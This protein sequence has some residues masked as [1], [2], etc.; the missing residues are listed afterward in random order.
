VARPN[1]ESSAA[2]AV[3]GTVENHVQLAAA[4]LMAATGAAV[5]VCPGI[6][7]GLAVAALWRWRSRPPVYLRVAVA[8]VALVPLFAL[9][10]FVE[11][12]WLWRDM[13]ANALPS[14]LKGVDGAL[15]LR[16]VPIEALAGAACLEL[17]GVAITLATRTIGGQI[18]RD[19]RLDR[20]RWRAISGHRGLID[21]LQAMLNQDSYSSSAAHPS[22]FVRLG[23]DAEI[24]RPLD[25]RLPNELATHV[26]IPGTSG[27][28]K[29]TTLARLADGAIAS[30][31]G[32]IF[33]DCKGGGL[34]ATARKLAA[35]YRVPFFLVD[36]DDPASLGYNP[37]S[38]DASAVANKLVGAFT[39]GPA[40]EIYKNIAMEAVP[41]AVRGLMATGEKVTL[42]ALRAVFGTRGFAKLAQN[43]DTSDPQNDRLK[44]RLLDLSALETDRVSRSGQA[45]LQRR[46]GALLEGKFGELF[47]ADEV[48]DWDNVLA[49]PSVTYVALST[50]ASSEDVELFGRVIAQDLKQVCARRITAADQGQYVV[51]ALA[52]F[53]EFAALREAEQLADLGFQARQALMSLVISTQYIPETIELRKAA[54][55][56]GLILAHR[57]ESQDAQDIADQFGTRKR[58]EITHQ[59]DFVTGFAEKGSA[60]RV[61]TY[62]V[63]PN[64]LRTLKVGRLALMSVERERH[65]IVNVYRDGG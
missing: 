21:R 4:L 56:A 3:Q 18:R 44:K 43:I 39:Y 1:I 24:N 45:G 19:H 55:S 26:F 15:V 34:R 65:A 16:S 9:R 46:L 2:P 7:V 22:G 28:G 53:D 60:R 12:A 62:N 35:R 61:D 50:L 41:L 64:V 13:L 5:A 47:R 17:F 27:A 40:A 42:E 29:T 31:Y 32:A 30:G 23:V 6:L 48:L 20:Q 25:L 58:N 36:P 57:V 63:N 11:V 14:A 38:G 51:P 37:C 8:V 10:S 33:I 59:V 54:L 52:V 49:Q